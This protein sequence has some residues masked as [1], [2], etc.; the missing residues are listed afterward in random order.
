[1][2]AKDIY[3]DI[4]VQLLMDEGWKITDDPLFLSYGGR[5]LFIDLGAER[6]AIAAE[7]D[8]RKIAVEIKSFLKPSP[9]KDLGDAIGQYGIYQ[10]VLS[11]IEPKRELYLAV[12]KRTYETILT[13][14]L[15]QLILRNWQI[16]LIIF[17]EE[18]RSMIQW[19]P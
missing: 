18:K 1:M 11:E 7:K 17:D 15:G 12:P 5:D 3:H 8:D 13:E 6:K 14:K 2:P 4:V 16:K 10:S 19:I 9:I